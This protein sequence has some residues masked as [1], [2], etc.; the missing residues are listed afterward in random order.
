MG[1]HV[2][3]PWEVGKYIQERHGRD[4]LIVSRKDWNRV[5]RVVKKYPEVNEKLKA[6]DLVLSPVILRGGKDAARKGKK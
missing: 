5:R 4:V 1:V 3:I 2:S 6:L